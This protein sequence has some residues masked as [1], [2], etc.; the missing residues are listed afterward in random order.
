M[1]KVLYRA[2]RPE[3]FSEMLG[4]EHIVR[5]LQNQLRRGEVNHAY[6]FCGTRGTG[7]TT[8]A[9]LLAKG[10]NCLSD[11]ERPCGRCANCRAIQN[12]TFMDL[13][14]IDAASNNG[15][16]NIRELRETVNYPPVVG[17]CKVYLIDEVHML[18]ASAFNALLKTLEEPPEGILFILCTT[19][20]EKLPATIL[21]RCMRMDFRR[22]PERQL[23]DAF[24]RICAERGIEAED[25]ALRLIAANADGSVRDGLTILDQ[26]LAGREDVLTRDDVL[27]ALGAVDEDTYLRLTELT[28]AQKPAEALLLLG[29]LLDGGRDARQ[30]LQGW[31]AHY[32]NLM[33]GKFMHDENEQILNM[34]IENITRVREQ[35]A[36][37]PLEAITEAIVEISHTM[38]EML[39]TTQPRILLEVCLVRLATRHSD[40]ALPPHGQNVHGQSAPAAGRR[41]I[42]AGRPDT[43]GGEN[44]VP[45]R[46]AA[47][48]EKQAPGK[49]DAPAAEKQEPAAADE[50]AV[51]DAAEEAAAQ[52]TAAAG[53]LAEMWND[54]IAAGEERRGDFAI[55]RAVVPSR[56]NDRELEL[57]ASSTMTRS[58]LEQNRQLVQELVA[59][60]LGGPR[61]LVIRGSGEEESEASPG[62][63]AEAVAARVRALDSGIKV[64]IE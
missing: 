28:E 45:A 32:R 17:R 38:R 48:A 31:L 50:T 24:A 36:S 57:L 4:Q 40:E 21:S 37:L 29:Q 10:V 34:S 15:V 7:K 19:A 13:I 11:G 22:V 39:T 2:C 43:A 12:G 23:V 3:V 18:S 9:R 20:P 30:I 53:D 63:P 8:T 54:V 51:P 25:F 27:A 14:E 55:L 42:S 59:A 52:Q 6:L 1:Y 61:R 64:D 41:T 56:M 46:A 33:I 62:S 44:A 60:R 5:V 47:A 35:A 49:T 58:Y 16:D 26:C